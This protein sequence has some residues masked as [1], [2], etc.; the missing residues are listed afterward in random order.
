MHKTRKSRVIDE[1][2]EPLVK[3]LRACGC[4]LRNSVPNGVLKPLSMSPAR[5]RHAAKLSSNGSD[6]INCG[7]EYTLSR[8]PSILPPKPGFDILN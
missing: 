5:D 1:K 7:G 8:P 6:G 3:R 2:W 4:P